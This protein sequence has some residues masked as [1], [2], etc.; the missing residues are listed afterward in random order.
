RKFFAGLV[1]ALLAG[2]ALA[3]TPV[4]QLA[5]PPANAD[6][7]MITSVGGGEHGQTSSWTTPD[8]THWS[9]FS[10][11]LRG[12]VSEV[13]QQMKLA[14]DGNIASLSVRG[15]TPSGDAAETFEAKTGTY[16][17]TSPVDHGTGKTKA[18]LLR[19]VRRYAGLEPADHA[20]ADEGRR[21]GHRSSAW[22][23]C[24]PRKTDGPQDLQRQGNEDCHLLRYHGLPP[25]A[26]PDLDGRHEVLRRRRRHRSPAAGMGRAGP[27]A[28]QGAGRGAGQARAG[29]RGPHR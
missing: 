1:V 15:F 6:V 18:P 17:F 19:I 20:A 2:P 28:G 13:D 12:L 9:R 23:P 26:V 16:T 27:H 29:A 11:N 5:K 10:M 22:R 7:W 25:F 4:E 3:Q 14:P 24:R 21:E 8:G